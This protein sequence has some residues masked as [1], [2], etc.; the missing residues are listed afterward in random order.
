MNINPR[1]ASKELFNPLTKCVIPSPVAPARAFGEVCRL[2]GLPVEVAI[3]RY[4]LHATIH[5]LSGSNTLPY[6]MRL[7]AIIA[8]DTT[9]GCPWAHV[10]DKGFRSIPQE[11]K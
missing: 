3:K 8:T 9:A 11:T 6:A 10:T 4:K 1:C 5:R 2:A 7:A